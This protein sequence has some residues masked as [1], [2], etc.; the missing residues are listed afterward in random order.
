M[1]LNILNNKSVWKFLVL[2]SYSPGAGYTRKEIMKLLRWNNLSLDR[3][4]N[5][6]LFY[7]IITKKSRIIKLDFENERTPVLLDVIEKEKKLLNYPSF[8]VFIILVEFLRLIED[9]KV[10]SVYMF[11]S[12]AKKTASVS[13]DIDIAVFAKQKVNL[14]EAKD[15]ILQQYGKEVQ[16][17]Y[18]RI[19]EKTKMIDEVMKHG[20]RLL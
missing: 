2:A 20:V 3:T 10:D 9:F 13:S 16:L 8:E 17:H 15:A 1:I 6:L 12:H 7:G 5:K 4:L 18:F 19:N 11:G 14:I